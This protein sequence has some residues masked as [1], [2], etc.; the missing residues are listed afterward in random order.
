M[1]KVAERIN[2]LGG[3]PDFNPASHRG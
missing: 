2:Q 3:R 1:P